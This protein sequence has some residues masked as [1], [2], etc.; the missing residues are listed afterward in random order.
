[1]HTDFPRTDEVCVDVYF[2]MS[3]FDLRHDSAENTIS[4]QMALKSV[5]Q[6]SLI[7]TKE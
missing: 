3:A 4:A 5:W 6:P 1:M 7:D 2:R